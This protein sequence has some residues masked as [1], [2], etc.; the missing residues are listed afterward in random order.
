MSSEVSPV[1]C[2]GFSRAE[3]PIVNGTLS[4]LTAHA[5]SIKVAFEKDCGDI[6]RCWKAASD[7]TGLTD[8]RLP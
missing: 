1:L 8:S 4:I 6:Y 3:F 7:A 2:M 5:V